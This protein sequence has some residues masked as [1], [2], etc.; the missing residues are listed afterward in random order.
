MSKRNAPPP[1]LLRKQR[2]WSPDAHRDAAWRRRKVSH[3]LG[4]RCQSVTDDDL[5]ELKGFIDLGFSFKP[6]SPDLDPKL[7]DTLPAL[8]FY[9]SV[10]KQYSDRFSRSASSSSFFSDTNSGSST[11]TIFD[12]E[13]SPQMVK[14]RLK[15][16]AQ[17]VAC[18]VK[19][20]KGE[21]N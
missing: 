6:D 2:S 13:D 14:T 15:Q 8:G 20:I 12:P 7:S 1:P 3:Q 17:V 16:W 5:Q 18:T 19:Q 10:N 4:R 21:Q 11:T 9:C